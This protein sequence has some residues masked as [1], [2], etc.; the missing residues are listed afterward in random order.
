M[1]A[2]ATKQMGVGIQHK[3]QLQSFS[4]SVGEALGMETLGIQPPRCSLALSLSWVPVFTRKNFTQAAI[5]FFFFC[6]I[7]Q[8]WHS[9]CAE[10]LHP[11]TSVL[12]LSCG[13]LRSSFISFCTDLRVATDG[14]LWVMKGAGLPDVGSSWCTL[15]AFEHL[16]LEQQH[17][18]FS[19]DGPDELLQNPWIASWLPSGMNPGDGK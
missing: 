6:K 7:C 9:R 10:Y 19:E 11:D 13:P 5:F 8:S 3:I 16:Q 17:A 18:G 4:L 15:G 1:V 2:E 14:S 12:L